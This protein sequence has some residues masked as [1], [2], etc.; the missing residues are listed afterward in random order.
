MST[1]RLTVLLLL[2]AAVAVAA[3]PEQA[4]SPETAAAL[5]RANEFFKGN[6]I[7]LW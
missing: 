1:T 7:T 6:G 5:K 4:P 2:G 3:A